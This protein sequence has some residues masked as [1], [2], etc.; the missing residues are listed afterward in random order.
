MLDEADCEGSRVGGATVS[1]MD[2][3]PETDE[4]PDAVPGDA[5][6]DPDDAHAVMI[7]HPTAATRATSAR[8]CRVMILTASALLRIVSF[9]CV[10][11]ALVP[12]REQAG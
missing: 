9:I 4:A 6:D 3:V 7:M 1:P 12:G 10:L 5:V 2:S 11:P 8:R